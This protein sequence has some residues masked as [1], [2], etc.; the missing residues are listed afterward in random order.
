MRGTLAQAC[1]RAPPHRP[2][3]IDSASPRR[4]RQRPHSGHRQDPPHQRWHAITAP[5]TSTT[6]CCSAI[7]A[8]NS[9]ATKAEIS[10]SMAPEQLL[11]DPRLE[12]S[13]GGR[14]LER[15]AQNLRLRGE[16]F[17][18]HRDRSRYRST[19]SRSRLFYP[20]VRDRR[21]GLRTPSLV[22]RTVPARPRGGVHRTPAQREP[23]PMARFHVSA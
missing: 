10:A 5:R 6:A 20:P 9:S 17:A 8:T 23:Q 1:P 21:R 3:R 13:V 22:H 18:N 14:R 19:L 15:G 2:R 16:P 7:S 4:A 12:R 11:R